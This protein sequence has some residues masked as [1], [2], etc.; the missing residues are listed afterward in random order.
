MQNQ[1]AEFAQPIK[2]GPYA[3]TRER[4]RLRAEMAAAEMAAS[5]ALYDDGTEAGTPMDVDGLAPPGDA[6]RSRSL[7]KGPAPIAPAGLPVTQQNLQRQQAHPT[8]G[9]VPPQTAA[10]P[11]AV[12]RPGPMLNTTSY[13]SAGGV[14]GPAPTPGTAPGLTPSFLTAAAAA[15]AA[16]GGGTF[17]RVQQGN[18]VNQAGPSMVNGSAPLAVQQ[19]PPAPRPPPVRVVARLPD[20]AGPSGP[21]PPSSGPGKISELMA[22]EQP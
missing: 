11:G 18:M 9:M 14:A 21:S 13:M 6:Q 8:R 22:S 4:E 20:P 15:A 3:K 19:P 5:P 1:P 7:S 17:P 10:V 16:S 12:A 2:R